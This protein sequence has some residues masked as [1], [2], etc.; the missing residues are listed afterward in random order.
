MAS[1]PEKGTMAPAAAPISTPRVTHSRPALVRFSVA[2]SSVGAQPLPASPVLPSSPLAQLA[3]LLAGG[4]H[5][6]DR[7]SN[8]I[9][10]IGSG[11]PMPNLPALPAPDTGSSALGSSVG[12]VGSPGSGS[13]CLL[14]AGLLVLIVCRRMRQQADRTPVSIVLSNP[15]PPG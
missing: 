13:A 8:L 5:A 14:L 12:G 15:V 11:L 10:F 1:A 6:P 9:S 7:L 4:L 2:L 3:Q